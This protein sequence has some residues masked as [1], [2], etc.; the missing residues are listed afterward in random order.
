M[1]KKQTVRDLTQGTPIVQILL[2]SLPL[3]LGTLFQQLYSF[4]DTVIVGRCIG[5][6]ALGALGTTYSLNFLTLGFVQGFCVGLG[7]PISKSFGAKDPH[8]LHRYLWNGLWLC[9]GISLLFS[10][11]M[12]AAAVPLL[13]L[14]HTPENLLGMAA[15]YIHIIFLGIPA[16]VLYNFS[17]SALRAVGDSKHPFYFLLFSSVLNILLDYLFIVPLQMGVAGA[18]AA[19]VISQLISGLLNSWWLLTRNEVYQIKKEELPFS[20]PHAFYL[21]K[22]AVPMGFEYSV[23][24]IGAIVMQNAINSLGSI[25]VAAQTTGEKI[26]QMFTLPMESVGM[27]MATYT[28]QNYGA[29]DIDRIKRGIKSGLTIQYLYCIAVWLIIRFS[30]PF[31]VRLVIGTAAGPEAEGAIQYLSIMSALFFIHGSL[32]IFRNT[33]QGLGRSFQA[34][35]S[36]VGELL[37]RSLG[38][39]AAIALSSYT[40]ICYTNPLAWGL[41]LVYCVIMVGLTLRKEKSRSLR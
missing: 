27:A 11:G 35:L 34:I 5:M 10:V 36:G 22:I 14:M 12:T 31:L 24:A 13:K 40:A 41:A 20:A 19:T 17:S 7:I 9:I 3:V 28:G 21:C 37:G 26:R 16:A 4:M 39:L 25:A 23:S 30:K 18:A 2:F 38:G 32:M 29:D 1:E 15:D 33:L 8:Q 6:D